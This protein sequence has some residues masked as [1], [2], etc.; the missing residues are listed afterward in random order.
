MPLSAATYVWPLSYDKLFPDTLAGLPAAAAI[1]FVVM[2]LIG[3]PLLA[4][5]YGKRFYCSWVCGCGGLAETFG[6]PWRHLS[7]KSNKAWR[8]EQ[9]SIYTVL[10]LV[11]LTTGLM[12]GDGVSRA[13]LVGEAKNAPA[14]AV[15]TELAALSAAVESGARTDLEA[16]ASEVTAAVTELSPPSWVTDKLAE[17]NEG[18][19][20]NDKQAVS[21]AINNLAYSVM[22]GGKLSPLAQKAKG[23]YSFF[24]G[25]MFAGVL[26]V[27]LYP[28]MGSRVWCRF[29]CPMAALL[30]F[31]Q[32]LGR[33]RIAVKKDMCISC[34]NCSTYCEMGIDV[35][36]YAMGNMDVR[37]ASCVGCGM[38]AHVCPRGVL[39]LT[40]A[41][42]LGP[43]AKVGEWMVDL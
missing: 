36:A 27:G 5:R 3:F 7:D 8:I 2:S 37:R 20:K 41:A 33:F 30:G 13:A 1:Y 11:L 26:G 23:F 39:R 9:Y 6:D 29:G 28:L 34:G 43:G 10:G 16:V 40:S 25:A 17:V 22:P 42:D 31:M 38:C 14:I 32:K 15:S 18:S 35:R 12:I 21:Q 24:I 19:A 4:W